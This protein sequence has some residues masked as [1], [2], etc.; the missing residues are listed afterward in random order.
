MIRPTY[1]DFKEQALKDPVL[2]KAYDDLEEEYKITEDD[3][4]QQI[5]NDAVRQ[6]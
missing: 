1:E 2:K 4:I 5:A 6:V 3:L